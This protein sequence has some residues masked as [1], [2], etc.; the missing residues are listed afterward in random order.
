[1]YT[2][3]Y[4]VMTVVEHANELCH[5]GYIQLMTVYSHT[6]IIMMGDDCVEQSSRDHTDE[7]SVIIL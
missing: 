3:V 5:R 6:Y 7:L 2:C 1:M 4:V